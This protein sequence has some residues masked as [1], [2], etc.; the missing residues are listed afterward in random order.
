MHNLHIGCIIYIMCCIIYIFFK[1]LIGIGKIFYFDSKAI[2]TINK[3]LCSERYK[4]WVVLLV[5]IIQGSHVLAVTDQPIDRREMFTLSKLLIQTPKHL[6]K[7]NNTMFKIL[8]RIFYSGI[9]VIFFI[10]RTI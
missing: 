1:S 9:S 8:Q 2:N 6:N 7:E 5:I 10:M 4:L 3:Y